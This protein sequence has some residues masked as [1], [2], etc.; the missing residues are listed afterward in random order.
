MNALPDAVNACLITDA[1]RRR[2]VLRSGA[3][4][5]IAIESSRDTILSRI[6]RLNLKY[7][8]DAGHAPQT[9]ILKP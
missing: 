2:G 3:V 8:G 4:R 9:L 1:L 5:D 7:E 6:A